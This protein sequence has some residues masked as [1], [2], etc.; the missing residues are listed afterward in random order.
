MAQFREVACHK[1]ALDSLELVIFFLSEYLMSYGSMFDC[2]KKKYKYVVI[3][4][5]I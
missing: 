3:F 5:L 2:V 4:T 1:I